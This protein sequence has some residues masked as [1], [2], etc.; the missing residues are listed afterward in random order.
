MVI[1]DASIIIP[2]FNARDTILETID[3]AL[4]QVD[5][6]VEVIVV[7]DG[8]I[9]DTEDLLKE[10]G[11]LDRVVYIYQPNQGL[12]AARNAGL[13]LA[14][15]QYI[16]F[17]DSDDLLEPCFL[18]DMKALLSERGL[19]VAYSDY[20]YFPHGDF[21]ETINLRYPIYEGNVTGKLIREHFIPTPGC[22][23]IDRHA[24][25][26]LRFDEKRRYVEDWPFWI[27]LSLTEEF[28]FC[29]N[30]F[31]HI[32]RKQGSLGSN[33]PE[34]GKGIVSVMEMVEILLSKNPSIVER[35]DIARFYYRYA[36]YLSQIGNYRS[37]LRKW[38][39]AGK[40]GLPFRM[41]G[42]LAAKIVLQILGM[43]SVVE[44]ALWKR[45]IRS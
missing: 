17:L 15:G 31:V 19:H 13:A 23:L 9:D 41:H 1:P 16:C 38:G 40:T 4:S 2:S 10:S 5:A 43:S 33:K 14:R 30:V 36:S 45:R 11:R 39:E 28:A 34:M 8:S 12:A 32:R 18:R 35:E 24:L 3:S 29:P 37:A 42:I 26:E 44:G 22:V 27:S 6:N 7:N 20:R 25:G 21:S